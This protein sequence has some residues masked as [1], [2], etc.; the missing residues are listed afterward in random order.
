MHPPY[1]AYNPSFYGRGYYNR[2]SYLR[3][4]GPRAG[5]GGLL[6]VTLVGTCTYFICKKV[7]L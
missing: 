2:H 6:K 1:K 3:R 5:V 4:L 7:F